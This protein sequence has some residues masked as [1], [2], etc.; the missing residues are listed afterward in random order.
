MLKVHPSHRMCNCVAPVAPCHTVRYRLYLVQQSFGL[1][2][3]LGLCLLGL[4]HP[5][6]RCSGSIAATACVAAQAL[7]HLARHCSTSNSACSSPTV[8][9]PVQQHACRFAFSMSSLGIC[10][11]LCTFCQGSEDTLRP[12]TWWLRCI[13]FLARQCTIG[14]I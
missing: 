1:L 2:A 10:W 3:V 5:L 12:H 9:H 4:V 7:W 14:D 6:A 13:E 11:G 8:S